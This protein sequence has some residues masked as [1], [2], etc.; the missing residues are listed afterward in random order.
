MT[1]RRLLLSALVALSAAAT[2]PAFADVYY[3]TYTGTASGT[4]TFG[5]FGSAGATLNGVAFTSTYTYDPTQF[6][7]AEQDV[8][9]SYIDVIGGSNVGMTSPIL[10]ASLTINGDTFNQ[11]PLFYSIDQLADDPRYYSVD[12]IAKSSGSNY[13]VNRD[14]VTST[15]A[16]SFTSVQSFLPSSSSSNG[17]GLS[18][19]G[20]SIALSDAQITITDG[21]PAPTDVSEP[22]S[23]AL[24]AGAVGLLAALRGGRGATSRGHAGPRASLGFA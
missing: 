20:E 18:Y 16:L 8:A 21:P 12:N 24:L 3:V 1:T 10:S 19:N 15:V 17:G 14:F 22:A 11:S 23:L 6:G 9:S 13:L 5:L 7:N 2:R 4:D